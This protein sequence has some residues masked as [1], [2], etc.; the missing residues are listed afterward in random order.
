VTVGPN[1][2]ATLP[3]LRGRAHTHIN[4]INLQP[5][6]TKREMIR[7]TKRLAVNSSRPGCAVGGKSKPSSSSR[8][9]STDCDALSATHRDA[10][11]ARKVRACVWVTFVSRT[12]NLERSRCQGFPSLDLNYAKYSL[13]NPSSQYPPNLLDNC[14]INLPKRSYDN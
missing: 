6:H 7:R 9:A 3:S 11:S 14:R 4:E 8:S 1:R 12:F 10:L 13:P 5:P 2:N